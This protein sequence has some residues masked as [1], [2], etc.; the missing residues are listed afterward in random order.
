M[1][2]QDYSGD[3]ADL[4]A[5]ALATSTVRKTPDID[6]ALREVGKLVERRFKDGFTKSLLPGLED[7]VEGYTLINGDWSPHMAE[8]QGLT[9]KDNFESGLDD[10]VEKFVEPYEPY[11]SA[12]WLG[13]HTVESGVW[14]EGG[15]AQFCTNVAKEVYKTL[16]ADRT[17]AQQLASAGVVR[18][19]IETA[20][21]ALGK[22]TKPVTTDTPEADEVLRKIKAHVGDDFDM[23]TVY[24]DIDV[25]LNEDDDILAQSAGQRIG[26][27]EAD[28]EAL[29]C[30]ALNIDSDDIAD[31]LTT[32]I[33]EL[34]K[35]TNAPRRQNT[36]PAPDAVAANEKGH[37]EV[38]AA[39]KECGVPDTA[40][41]ETLGIS[42]TTYTNYVKGKAAFIPDAEQADAVRAEL[43]RRANVLLQAIH[44]FDGTDVQEVE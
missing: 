21:A 40:F 36:G 33:A 26:L 4:I 17:P 41:A 9:V 38:L 14:L 7:V 1:N 19:D 3:P 29:R 5:A 31:V 16:C 11:L 28:M 10:E 8:T 43:V 32:R 25:I 39:L 22:E 27:N 30:E 20:L 35:R 13:L 15:V 18:A 37:G 12:N 44:A 42:R 24:D 6:T 23:L 34:D 2:L